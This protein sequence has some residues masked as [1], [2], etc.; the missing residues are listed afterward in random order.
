MRLIINGFWEIE[1]QR[2]SSETSLSLQYS[3][4]L[5]ELNHSIDETILN[6]DDLFRKL[7][8][9]VNELMEEL[10]IENLE[11]AINSYNR[12]YLLNVIKDTEIEPVFLFNKIVNLA[13]KRAN[14]ILEEIK[15]CQGD[16]SNLRNS[17]FIRWNPEE[18]IRYWGSLV[19]ECQT[20]KT[21]N[22]LYWETSCRRCQSSLEGNTKEIRNPYNK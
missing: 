1:R 18:V 5:E 17:E 6:S 4:S 13:I 11:F 3:E 20:C 22:S 14:D 15:E 8:E 21:L 9:P 7:S 19:R 10:S 12:Y 16:L 2:L